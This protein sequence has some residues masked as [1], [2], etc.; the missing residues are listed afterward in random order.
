MAALEYSRTLEST[1]GGMGVAPELEP[2]WG[3]DLA[4]LTLGIGGA[5]GSH[6]KAQERFLDLMQG[7]GARWA[8]KAVTLH[9]WRWSGVYCRIA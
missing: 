7:R 8:V 4:L 9:G 2:S 5:G 3:G 1:R 6:M